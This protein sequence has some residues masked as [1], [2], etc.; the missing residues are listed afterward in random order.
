MSKLP[1]QEKPI[2]FIFGVDEDFFTDDER[3]EIP[4]LGIKK[5]RQKL[6]GKINGV[7]DEI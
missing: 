2:Y 7:D 4:K 3:G 5:S 1:R 6:S